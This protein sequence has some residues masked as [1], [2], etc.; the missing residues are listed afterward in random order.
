MS[1]RAACERRIIA[2][3]AVGLGERKS[4]N[5]F[6]LARGSRS[7]ISTSNPEMERR[8]SSDGAELKL[9][10]ECGNEVLVSAAPGFSR[11]TAGVLRAKSATLP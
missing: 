9:V 7:Q 2:R 10:D 1:L 11:E 3:R 8:L 5:D 6:D 4:R